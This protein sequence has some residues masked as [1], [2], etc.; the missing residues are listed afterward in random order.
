[1]A[2]KYF[3]K[4]IKIKAEDS[5]NVRL[6][7]EEMAAGREPSGTVVVQG[8]LPYPTYLQRRALWDPEQQCVGLDAEF[9]EGGTVLL[10]PPLWLNT[11]EMRARELAADANRQRK[12]E[13]KAIGIDTAEGGDDTAMAAVDE[14]GVMDLEAKK[15]PN[16]AVV[17]GDVIAFGR[18]WNV[19]PENWIFDRGGGGKW[20]ADMLRERGMN[21][22]TVG[23]NEI[24]VPDIHT[25]MATIEER[26]EVR[27]SR[28]A[29]KNRRAQMYGELATLMDPEG[30]E[31]LS[32][33]IPARYGELRRQLS[34]IP[35][36]RDNGGRL[37]LPPKRS[38]KPGEL[39]LE[40]ILGCSP[41]E[42][43]ALVLAVHGMLHGER[44]MSAGALG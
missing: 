16:T 38:T 6:A 41:D 9:W 19:P 39:T 35:K 7:L 27:E 15:T 11:A 28:Y 31:G 23:F 44:V 3:R 40:A 26:E 22:R 17:I 20:V 33:A 12:R 2:L 21:C 34:L 14:Y 29:Y 18:K 13:A 10:Y 25:G 5:P 8:V 42:A 30:Y 37:Y 24:I 4:V 1:M 43:D 36:M 32:F